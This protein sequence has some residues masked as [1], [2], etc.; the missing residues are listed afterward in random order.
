MKLI[1]P[2]WFLDCTE[3][4][5]PQINTLHYGLL[6]RISVRKYRGSNLNVD[7]IFCGVHGWKSELTKR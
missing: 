6:L 5:G 3:L 7:T 4:G 1:F 2:L